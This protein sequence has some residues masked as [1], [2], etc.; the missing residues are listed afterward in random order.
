MCSPIGRESLE[1]STTS[2]A[3]RARRSRSGDALRTMEMTSTSLRRASWSSIVATAELP[4]VSAITSPAWAFD[5][6]S[7]SHAVMTLPS[8]VAVSKE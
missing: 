3:P 5:R 6:A 8:C 4:A 1:S 2:R 7:M